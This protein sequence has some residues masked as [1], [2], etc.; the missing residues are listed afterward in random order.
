MMKILKM[1]ISWPVFLLI[2]IAASGLL[3]V[4]MIQLGVLPQMYL[5]GLA[6]ILLF[7]SLMTFLLMR[8][9]KVEGKGRVR[10]VIGRLLSILLSVLFVIGSTYVNQGTEVMEDATEVSEQ[11]S[12]FS[13]FVLQDSSVEQLTDLSFKTVGM[14][15]EYDTEA[16]FTEAYRALFSENSDIRFAEYGK[17]TDLIDALYNKEIEAIYVNEGYNGL[18]E[19]VYETFLTDI[20]SLWSY[21]IVEKNIDISKKVDVTNS[22]FTIFISGIDTSGKVSTVSRSDVNMLVT[23]NPVS[24]DI[25]MVSIPRDYYVT[26]ANKGK[27]DKLTHAGLG[28]VDNSVKTV[29][30]FMGIDINY[31]V[32]VNFTSLTKIVDALG[33]ITV[34]SPVAFKTRHGN[35]QVVK[36]QNE[37]NGEQAL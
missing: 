31:Y 14:S 16:H 8:P 23:V 19:E 12:R 21:D 7:L 18:F 27:A 22:A 6:G 4:R 28:G 3:V 9:S 33:G 29:E 32:R 30:E 37:M 24:K 15:G 13:L 25:L 34:E 36:G 2:Q 26:L 10:Q 35:Y 20:K 17:Y 5:Y 1:I 11:T